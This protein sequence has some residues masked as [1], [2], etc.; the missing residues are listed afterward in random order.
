MA[1]IKRDQGIAIL[2]A[3]KGKAT[4]V[5][6][7]DAYIQKAEQLLSDETTYKLLQSDPTSTILVKRS[8]V[9]FRKRL[10]LVRT[11]SQKCTKMAALYI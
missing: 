5:L 10:S 11:S 9:L 1:S 8:T 7:C 3:S 4:V 6:D 2:P